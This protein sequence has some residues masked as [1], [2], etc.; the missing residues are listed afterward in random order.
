[1]A[2]GDAP[3]DYDFPNKGR[4]LISRAEG[5]M[6]TYVAGEQVFERGVHAGGL[7]GRVLRSHES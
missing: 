2:D 1:M 7:A 6:A 5:V 3:P 4:R